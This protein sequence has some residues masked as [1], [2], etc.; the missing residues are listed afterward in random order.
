MER[1]RE[2]KA[3]AVKLKGG[4][5]SICSYDKSI[6]ALEFHH[7]NPETKEENINKFT[8]WPKVEKELEKCILVCSNC[9]RELHSQKPS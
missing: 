2:I 8:S 3:M 4:C 7:T 6:A 5:C 9:H 1:Q